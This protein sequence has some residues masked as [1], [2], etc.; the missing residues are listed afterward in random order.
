MKWTV[1]IFLLMG[2][3]PLALYA[4]NLLFSPCFKRLRGLFDY[5]RKNVDVSVKVG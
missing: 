4:L 5:T 2:V 3:I 1:V